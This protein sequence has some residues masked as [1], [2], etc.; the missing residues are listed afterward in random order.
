MA[1][2]NEA[3]PLK[4]FLMGNEVAGAGHRARWACMA[5]RS[6]SG[7]EILMWWAKE[8]SWIA[9]MDAGLIEFGGH[10]LPAD[11]ERLKKLGL[12]KDKT[13]IARFVRCFLRYEDPPDL[14][15]L[16]RLSAFGN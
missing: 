13:W 3:M 8:A 16:A 12:T 6:P 4:Q 1:V 7:S 2:L 9:K 10:H 14:Q 5:I 11:L 15:I